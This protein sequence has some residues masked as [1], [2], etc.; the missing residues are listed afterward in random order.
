MEM[1]EIVVRRW[2][3]IRR[4]SIWVI[5]IRTSESD[6]VWMTRCANSTWPDVAKLDLDAIE[7][8]R[9]RRRWAS[10]SGGDDPENQCASLMQIGVKH[11]FEMRIEG[12][13][14]GYPECDRLFV[15]L[16]GVI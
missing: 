11:H 1:L 9:V 6:A 14:K 8:Q 5:I 2:T 7:E 15:M 13:A 16:Q 3:A 10:R 4:V 12:S